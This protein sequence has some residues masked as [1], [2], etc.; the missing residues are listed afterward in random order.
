ME[1]KE[2]TDDTEGSGA[3]K[4]DFTNGF[5]GPGGHQ[6]IVGLKQLVKVARKIESNIESIY[7][8]YS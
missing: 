3:W 4:G 7:F 8:K 1:H 5:I 2:Y 6:K